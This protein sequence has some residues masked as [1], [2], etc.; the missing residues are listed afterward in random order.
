[1]NQLY[2]EIAEQP[3]V[4]RRIAASCITEEQFLAW[5]RQL[6]GRIYF[7]GM[8]SS[9][10]AAYP[11]YLYL[12]EGGFPVEWIDASEFLHYGLGGIRNQDTLFLLSQS[13]ESYEILKI[14]EKLS[15]K[16]YRI[17]VTASLESTMAKK[18]DT[19]IDILSGP[20]KA[21]TSTKTHTA[22][23]SVLNL[24][25]MAYRGDREGFFRAKGEL[26]NVADEAERLITSSPEWARRAI[27]NL[28]LLQES[29]AR[30][31]IARGYSLSAA[32]HGCLSF[33]ECAKETFLS[34]SGGQFR[35]G[36][37]ELAVKK[38][39]AVLLMPPGRTA[40][41]MQG[42]AEFLVQKGVK[43]LSI[44]Q[45]ALAPRYNLEV[46]P[47]YANNEFFA[48]LLSIITIMLLSYYIAEE[49]GIEP[50]TAYLIKKITL[51]E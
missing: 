24:W 47:F 40:I 1:M 34:F 28:E 39:L 42:L 6:P 29:D 8:G 23:L 2:R 36:P 18:C 11:A 48:P 44:G 12:L 32:W 35:H 45:C 15:V 25:A 4:F 41:P 27:Y 10:F 51:E 17:G 33:Y 16:P 20:E 43:V 31:I 46:L 50:G 3:E 21:I 30:V 7:V 14:L 5:Q 22:M 19:I 49:K 13:G 37:L 9:L 26:E 38:M